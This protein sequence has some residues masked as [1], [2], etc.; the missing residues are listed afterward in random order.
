MEA[1]RVVNNR[2]IMRTIIIFGIEVIIFKDKKAPKD[3]LKLFSPNSVLCSSRL[4]KEAS[5]D[6]CLVVFSP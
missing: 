3:L 2:A 4:K 5:L 6:S 1:P